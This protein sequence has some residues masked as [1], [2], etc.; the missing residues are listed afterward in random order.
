METVVALSI[1]AVALSFFVAAYAPATIG[2]QR[3]NSVKE[4]KYLATAVEAEL[5]TLR[6]SFD[7]VANSSFEKAYNLVS[8]GR[9]LIAHK[10]RADI[11]GT[12]TDG[13]YEGFTGDFTTAEDSEEQ[14]MKIQSF[15][16]DL[17]NT[18]GFAGGTLPLD[19][20]EGSCFAVSLSHLVNTGGTLAPSTVALDP[21]APVILVQADFYLLESNAPAYIRNLTP[22]DLPSRPIYSTRFGITR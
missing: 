12:N 10:Y 9:L 6:S 13:I 2:I 19:S 11:N 15:V 21:Q 4:A 14:P 1:A 8:G 17:A 16:M 20:I 5:N 18:I 3:A 22:A 7:G